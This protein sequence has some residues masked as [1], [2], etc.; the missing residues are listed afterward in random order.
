MRPMSK[1][2]KGQV[3]GAVILSGSTIGIYIH[4]FSAKKAETQ[5]MNQTALSPTPQQANAT[6]IFPIK[7]ELNPKL[8]V[9][10]K[11]GGKQT[12]NAP[13]FEKTHINL[14][15][16]ERKKDQIH[17]KEEDW[18][19]NH[20][21]I[22]ARYKEGKADKVEIETAIRELDLIEQLAAEINDHK[23]QGWADQQKINLQMID[24]PYIRQGR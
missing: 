8:P 15:T 13:T 11:K 10:P 1:N 21:G 5:T 24:V 19:K 22:I 9:S 16:L 7:P 14:S 18:V 6:P 12:D 23:S 4:T 20:P 17:Q 2:V 3:I